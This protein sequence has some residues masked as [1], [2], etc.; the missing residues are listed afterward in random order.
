M[1]KYL[2]SPDDSVVAFNISMQ[3]RNA[4]ALSITPLLKVWFADTDPTIQ[5][6]S[7][8]S[9]R[10]STPNLV[11]SWQLHPGYQ[12]RAEIGLRKRKFIT[13]SFFRDV[14]AGNNPVSCFLTAPNNGLAKLVTELFDS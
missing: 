14:V 7:D 1:S 3:S 8:I 9:G 11:A 4:S 12:W 6:I 2:I 10:F 13:S 5:N